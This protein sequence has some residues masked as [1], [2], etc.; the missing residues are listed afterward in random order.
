MTGPYVNRT[1]SDQG[2]EPRRGAEFGSARRLLRRL[3]EVVAE[4]ISP[5]QRL[6]RIVKMIAANLVAEVC[7]VYAQ[8][9]GDVIE[10][11]A[12]EGLAGEAVHHVR[13]RV[14]EGLVGRIAATGVVIN[15]ADA[16][17]HPNF[18]YFPE[19]REEN[20]A[21]FLGVP[22]LR[23]GRVVGVLTVQNSA[24]RI[25]SEEE[26]EALQIIASVLA[27]MFAS[28]GLVD[29]AQYGD[30][31]GLS[32]EP[33]RLEGRRLVDG[34]AVGHA[35]LHEARV[36]IERLLSDDPAYERDRVDAAMEELK[37]SL[38]A[39]LAR[40]DLA[41]G[42]HREVLE[43]YR[44]VAQD[45]GWRRRIRE[46]VDTGLSAEAAVRRVQEETRLRIG[47]ASDPYLRERLLDLDDLA[48]RLLRHLTGAAL[49]GPADLP[50]DA[51]IVAR[52]LSA[53][54]L[55]EYDRT[56]LR[57]IILEEGSLTAHVTIV[58]RAFNIPVVGR[59]DSAMSLIESGDIVALDGSH[60]TLFLRP[61]DDVLHA[62]TRTVQL[63]A[64]QRQAYQALRVQPAITLD[65]I[66][67]RLSINAAFLADLVGF[68][69]SGA[70]GIGLF[71]TE[72]AFMTRSTLPTVADQAAH[73][74]DVLD[75]TQ[76]KPVIFRT[77]DI[78]SDKQVSYW[79]MPAEDNPALGWRA[80]RMM[81]DRPAILAAQL[82][83]MARAA[84]E[85]ELY[86]MFPMVA[87]VDELIA[88]RRILDREV[89]QARLAG[90]GP[91]QV[92][93][94][95]MLE[96]PAL[97]FQLDDLLPLIDFVSVGTN[98]LAQFLFACD[99]GNPAVAERYDLLSPA[100]LNLIEHLAQR[101]QA[102]GVSLGVCG[103]M[104]SR[105]IE[106]MALVALG[107]HHLSVVAS[108]IGPIKAMIR[109]LDA[110]RLREFLHTARN[111]AGRRTGGS[112][113]R[114]SMIDW[115][116]DHGIALPD[117]GTWATTLDPQ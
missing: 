16:Q 113:L 42:E 21:S 22:I 9:A 71:R 95:V 47:H 101:C 110:S 98:D 34:V 66:K 38:D 41:A 40:S 44:M 36:E 2:A 4:Q 112:H 116:V 46:A 30:V 109:S 49:Q 32:H 83:A 59:V 105:P 85:R 14:G 11:F 92:T 7:S 19:T 69:E 17:G 23:S 75:R 82:R 93:V 87:D 79:R 12:T 58:A 26:V 5:Q 107:V 96:V 100:L 62:F 51:I 72:L 25:Y 76:G 27:E 102:Y 84:A 97:M 56:R 91:R 70:D 99:R 8:R 89:N 90:Q 57:G 29:P 3:I 24:R 61:T 54:E 77:L 64:E 18:R 115:A 13:M 74:R 80:M 39:M 94:G 6:D 55:V 86:I 52:N 106:A 81:L 35:F 43:T 67:I 28:G 45:T 104:A 60:G 111:W 108:E 20:Y 117:I 114:A 65:G 15:T 50:D 78:G 103:E 73:Y 1:T 10:L 31:P 53:A 33:Q 88:A 48:N 37:A 68:E 63:Q